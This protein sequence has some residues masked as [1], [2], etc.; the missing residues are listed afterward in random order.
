MRKTQHI[1]RNSRVGDGFYKSCRILICV[2]DSG[3]LA[4]IPR[5]ETECKRNLICGGHIGFIFPTDC[6]ANN[7]TFL[8]VSILNPS[9]DR[10]TL[11]QVEFSAQSY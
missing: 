1:A 6:S 8:P 11:I 5:P 4:L 3:Q 7:S 9:V 2:T 10:L